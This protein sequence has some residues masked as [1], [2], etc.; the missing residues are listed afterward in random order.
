MFSY[1]AEVKEIMGR[2]NNQPMPLF[3]LCCYLS[4]DYDAPRYIHGDV[5]SGKVKLP[6]VVTRYGVVFHPTGGREDMAEIEA[7]DQLKQTA[8]YNPVTPIE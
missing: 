7:L 8:R 1:Y 3:N 4:F 6:I 2:F 5:R